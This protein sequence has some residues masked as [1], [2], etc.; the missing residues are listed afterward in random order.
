MLE[1]SRSR[2]NVIKLDSQSLRWP[3]DNQLL[4]KIL[5]LVDK[6][7]WRK[8]K[9]DLAKV[10]FL[11]AAGLGKIVSLHHSLKA[12][13][14]RLVL[15]NVGENAFEVFTVTRLTGVLDIQRF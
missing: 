6:H 9:L 5:S 7:A 13:N 14:V 3:V 15:Q 11:T 2:P 10:D 1:L 8:V 12:Q 4:A